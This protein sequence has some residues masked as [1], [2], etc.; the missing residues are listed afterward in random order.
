MEGG[1]ELSHQF[2][3]PHPPPP[4]RRVTATALLVNATW[5]STSGVPGVAN[6]VRHDFNVIGK[7]AR[8]L[9]LSVTRQWRVG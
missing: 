6:T 2:V 3:H 7:L 8:L 1:G 4:G 5:E 9:S